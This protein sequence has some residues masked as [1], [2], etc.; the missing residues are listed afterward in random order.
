MKD[1]YLNEVGSIE[2]R[3]QARYDVLID[4]IKRIA[5]AGRMSFYPD[6]V[7]TKRVTVT[8]IEVGLGRTFWQD[9][10]GGLLVPSGYLRADEVTELISSVG[11]E[12]S[13]LR[14]V[15]RVNDAELNAR[16]EGK[17]KAVEGLTKELG[18]K[19]ATIEKLRFDLREARKKTR[20]TRKTRK[21]DP[22]TRV[23]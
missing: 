13:R 21:P 1:E 7:R 4:R 9:D 3:Y 10:D 12:N 14:E 8:R 22:M 6:D 17:A 11:E 15:I 16:L 5:E 2:D 18:R 20:K 23:K 19:T